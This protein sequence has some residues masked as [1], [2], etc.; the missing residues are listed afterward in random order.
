M[1]HDLKKR[2]KNVVS[3]TYLN[4]LGGRIRTYIGIL[5]S[6][7]F[8]FR[9]RMELGQQQGSPERKMRPFRGNTRTTRGVWRAEHR[10]S[11][12]PL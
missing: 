1:R 6:S 10:S 2:E 12:T 7:R 11:N 3:I 8:S 9:S 4:A 5:T